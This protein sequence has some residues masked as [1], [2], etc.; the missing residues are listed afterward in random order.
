MHCLAW[1][2]LSQNL[3]PPSQTDFV[4]FLLFFFVYNLNPNAWFISVK[5]NFSVK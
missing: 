5:K 2:D 1:I 3:P 4:T